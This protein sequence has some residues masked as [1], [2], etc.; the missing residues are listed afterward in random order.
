MTVNF[1]QSQKK[2]LNLPSLIYLFGN[3]MQSVLY[4]ATLIATLLSLTGCSNLPTSVKYGS[5]A[6]DN[7][8]GSLYGFSNNYA[9]AQE[10]DT[11]AL[12]ECGK[13]CKVVKNFSTGCAAYAADQAKG[14]VAYGWGSGVTGQEAKDKALEYCR[15]YGGT[16]CV[17]RVW[18]CNS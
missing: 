17:V 11:R 4:I 13:D 3:F 7:N 5:L 18:S 12:A 15:K 16:N 2:S 1:C 10:A 6:I 14:G 8:Q 9:T